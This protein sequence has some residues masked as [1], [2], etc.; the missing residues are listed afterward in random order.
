MGLRYFWRIF[1]FTWLVFCGGSF[2]R[3]NDGHFD[4]T[5]DMGIV[6]HNHLTKYIPF[7][8]NDNTCLWIIHGALDSSYL[9]FTVLWQAYSAFHTFP[10]FVV[11]RNQRSWRFLSPSY[12][13]KF[14]RLPMRV[15]SCW[16]DDNC[17]MLWRHRCR[18]STRQQYQIHCIS[19]GINLSHVIDE[20]LT[21]SL[22][23]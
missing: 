14:L 6:L 5:A 13:K 3:R 9:F 10:V 12:K 19:S 2:C 11:F 4:L 22:L 16:T 15:C 17:F 21:T 8:G 1:G 18:V 20:Y 23:L 7:V